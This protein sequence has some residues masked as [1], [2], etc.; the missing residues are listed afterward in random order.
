MATGPGGELEA[1]GGGHLRASHA[2]REQVIGLLKA[3]FVQ[4]RLTKDELDARAG[5]TFAARTYAELAAVTADLPAGVTDDVPSA[6]AARAQAGPPMSNAAMAGMWAVIA[7][8]VPVV[9]VSLTGSGQLFLLLTPFYFM[10]LAFLTAEMAASRHRNRSHR[11]QLPPR[12]APSGAG[13]ASEH[14][15]SAGPGRQLPP[16]D[17][18]PRHTAEAQRRR[19]PRPPVPLP[20]PAGGWRPAGCLPQPPAIGGRGSMA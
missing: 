5:Q 17:D 13:Q 4:G 16:A 18:A 8:A 11:G 12:P 19:L 2:D 7:V 20:R 9:L 14:P 1:A 10:A 6:R 3:A 15:L